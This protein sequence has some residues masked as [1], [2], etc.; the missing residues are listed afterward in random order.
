MNYSKKLWISNG[1]LNYLHLAQ[2]SHYTLELLCPLG[3]KAFLAQNWGDCR[4]TMC[5]PMFQCHIVFPKLLLPVYGELLGRTVWREEISNLMVTFSSRCLTF[6]PHLNIWK[7]LGNL[8]WKI[9]QNSVTKV[10]GLSPF[11]R[12]GIKAS[13]FLNTHLKPSSL[14]ESFRFYIYFLC[15]SQYCWEIC[16]PVPISFSFFFFPP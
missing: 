16:A 3:R 15:F 10:P 4:V 8:S 6:Y 5:V 2:N 11:L 9:K 14:I 12:K 7:R 13:G 1:W